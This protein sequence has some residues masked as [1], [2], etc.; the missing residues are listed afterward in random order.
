M[1]NNFSY[2]SPRGGHNRVLWTSTLFVILVLLV[3]VV[4]GGRVHSLARSGAAA[5][6]RSLGTITSSIGG[7][8]F[9]TS[10]ASLEAQDQALTEQLAQY[11]ERAAGYSALQAENAQ[12]RT[13]SNLAQT[14]PGI[15]APVVSSV[16]SSP[17]GTFLIGAGS[18]DGIVRGALVLTSG[19]FVVGKVS[20][21]GPHTSTVSELFAPG[22]SVNA[23]IHGTPIPVIGS[24]GGNAHASMPRGVAVQD[25]DIVSAPEFGQRPI[26]FVGAVASSSA[27]AAQ[28]VYIRLPGSL[29]A[30][31][32]V[33][34]VSS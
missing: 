16:I 19:G 27:Q 10:R 3:D 26:G 23:V 6:T 32:F 9:F 4:S 21:V 28:D 17:Y 7:S 12:L 13:L 29:G 15:T 11:Q 25:N 34:V 1:S 8:G 14:A 24:G 18:V 5:V 31:Q 2:R 22:A 30:L 20:D 33:Y